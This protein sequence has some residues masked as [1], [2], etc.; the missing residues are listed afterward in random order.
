MKYQEKMGKFRG[1]SSRLVRFAVLVGICGFPVQTLATGIAIFRSDDAVVIAVDSKTTVHDRGRVQGE[2]ETC[3]LTRLRDAVFVATGTTRTRRMTSNGLAT[4][5]DVRQLAMDLLNAPGSIED[6][7][8]KFRHVLEMTLAKTFKKRRQFDQRSGVPVLAV[9]IAAADNGVPVLWHLSYTPNDSPDQPLSL[10]PKSGLCAAGC[11]QPWTLMGQSQ[12][13]LDQIS[14]G[15]LQPL[16]SAPNR[17]ETARRFV[18]VMIEGAPARV[19][20]PIDVVEV[21]PDGQAVC[22]NCKIGCPAG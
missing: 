12:Y 18:E 1:Q 4:T 19:G 17:A 8:G 9:A 10:R 11:K 7:I 20:P 6:R 3:K 22:V 14:S 15:R 13:L 2:L 5:F 16:L 21:K